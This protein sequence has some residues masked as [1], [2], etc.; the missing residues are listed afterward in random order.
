MR[1]T[2]KTLEG[3]RAKRDF[4]W[5]KDKKMFSGGNVTWIEPWRTGKTQIC[6]NLKKLY[7]MEKSAW[8]KT[9]QFRENITVW[10]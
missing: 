4:L 10:L 8:I 9:E 1:G 7:P 5:L 2:N 3:F 6:E